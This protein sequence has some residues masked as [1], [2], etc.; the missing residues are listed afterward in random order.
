MCNI[1]THRPDLPG[2]MLFLIMA[3]VFQDAFSHAVEFVVVSGWEVCLDLVTIP[4]REGDKCFMF[5]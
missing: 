2:T 3:A 5:V 4:V 1:A